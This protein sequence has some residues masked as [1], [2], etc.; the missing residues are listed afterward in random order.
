MTF[1]WRVEVWVDGLGHLTRT[2]ADETTQPLPGELALIAP[3]RM[4]ETIDD[5][6][7]PAQAREYATVTILA[8]TAAELEPVKRGAKVCLGFK[9]PSS[10][11]GVGDG[12]DWRLAGIVDTY[13][14]RPLMGA[15]GQLRGVAADITVVDHRIG[16][17]STMDAGTTDRAQESS[18]ARLQ[19][20]L[21]GSGITSSPAPWLSSADPDRAARDASRTSALEWSEAICAS[22]V[23]V[24]G[25]GNPVGRVV[26][27]PE[28]DLSVYAIDGV[29]PIE[30]ETDPDNPLIIWDLIR[31]DKTASTSDRIDLAAGLVEFDGLRWVRAGQQVPTRVSASWDNAGTQSTVTWTTTD[32]AIRPVALA[33]D[34]DLVAAAPANRMARCFLPDPAASDWNADTLTYLMSDD[35]DGAPLPRVGTVVRVIDLPPDLSPDDATTYPGQVA[36]VDLTVESNRVTVDITTLPVVDLEIF[37]GGDAPATVWVSTFDGGNAATS[38]WV[39]DYDGGQ[40]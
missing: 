32:F 12:W 14:L 20:G 35:V 5:D 40:A 15:P 18:L 23:D 13:Q 19:A 27:R 17:L 30:D 33:F 11:A 38:S 8:N 29:V 31:Q 9:T 2:S 1:T 34:T 4:G 10:A 39:R 37:D 25:A 26:M 16:R 7:W 22:W 21:G 6:P 24:D 36:T 28:L 3:F